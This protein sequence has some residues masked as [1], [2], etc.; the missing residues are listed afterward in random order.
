MTEPRLNKHEQRTRATK[1]LLLD[2]AETLFLRDGYERAE[3]GEIASVAGRTK[4]AIYAHFKSKE[5][6]FLALIEEK[7]QVFLAGL[8]QRYPLAESSTQNLATM[9]Q[10]YLNGVQNHSFTML[11]LEFKLYALRHPES[12]ER[13]I[14]FLNHLTPPGLEENLASHF[15]KV[16]PGKDRIPRSIA[17]YALSPMLT[18]LVAESVFSPERFTPQ[19]VRMV[20]G[21]VFDAL[22]GVEESPEKVPAKKT[23][24]K[25]VRKT[26][27]S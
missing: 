14:E 12:Q 9:R 21:K 6:I 26:R 24:T 11:M 19:I 18:A 5:D 1:R 23:A 17:I 13:L 16:P 2:A 25:A 8:E 4:G 15:G 10:F 22:M 27:S 7:S 3:L 20:T